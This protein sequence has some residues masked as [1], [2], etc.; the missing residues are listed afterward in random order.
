MP[1][2]TVVSR[3]TSEPASPANT[4]RTKKGR[5]KAEARTAD[6]YSHEVEGLGPGVGFA[7]TEQGHG[8][9][10]HLPQARVPLDPLLVVVALALVVDHDA[11]ARSVLALAALLEQAHQPN[12]RQHHVRVPVLHHLEALVLHLDLCPLQQRRILSRIP[13]P[14]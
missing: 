10:D 3:Q 13:A 11:V 9:V 6:E 14:T 12:G 4:K 1:A 7:M 2:S 8:L 5:T